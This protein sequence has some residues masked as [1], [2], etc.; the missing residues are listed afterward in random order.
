MIVLIS[1]FT[2]N[3]PIRINLQHINKFSLVKML[4]FNFNLN[5]IN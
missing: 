5:E 1:F 3:I 2:R 4:M